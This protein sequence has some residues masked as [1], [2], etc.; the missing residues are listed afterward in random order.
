[1][2]SQ[3]RSFV[4]SEWRPWIN[5]WLQWRRHVRT[6]QDRRLVGD[7]TSVQCVAYR[8]VY[9]VQMMEWS[10]SPT[11]PYRSRHNPLH[12]GKVVC[13]ARHPTISYTLM[14][15]WRDRSQ[16]PVSTSRPLSLIYIITLF[17]YNN[18]ISV[19]SYVSSCFVEAILFIN[20]TIKLFLFY[21]VQAT[22][23]IERKYFCK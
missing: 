2:T 17:G 1:M 23:N 18:A 20:S 12:R 21:R 13:S 22:R 9:C 19:P 4:Q 3:L 10:V 14:S 15:A 5:S 16:F 6:R 7:V 11:D 8:T